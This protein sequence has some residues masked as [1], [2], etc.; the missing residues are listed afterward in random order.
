MKSWYIKSLSSKRAKA[1]AFLKR[2]PWACAEC[3]L[4]YFSFFM[5]K[6]DVWLLCN[7]VKTGLLCIKCADEK[8]KEV[9]NGIGIRLDDLKSAV[10]N[11]SVI[12]AFKSLDKN[13]E[14]FT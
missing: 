8:L 10:C 1:K 12:W 4:E 13:N 3:K 5:L 9:R 6:D 7:K 2:K 11:D 14:D